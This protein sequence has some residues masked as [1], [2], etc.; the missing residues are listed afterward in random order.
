MLESYLAG[1]PDVKNWVGD[2]EI[3]TDDKPTIEYFLSLPRGEGPAGSARHRAPARKRRTA[4]EG[5]LR[6]QG[7]LRKQGSS[8]CSEQGSQGEQVSSVAYAWIR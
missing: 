4:V 8:R 7:L 1:P 5:S 3:L 2:G 6:E